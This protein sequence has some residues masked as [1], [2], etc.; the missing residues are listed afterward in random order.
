MTA[1]VAVSRR[2]QKELID[3]DLLSALRDDFSARAASYDEFAEF[4]HENFRRLGELGLLALVVPKKFGGGS[5]QLTDVARLIGAVASGDASTALV[6]AMHCLMHAIL[7][8]R[9]PSIYETVARAAV[10]GGGVLNALRAEPDLGS[11]NRG[12]ALATVARPLA[13]GGWRIN[14][15]KA[16]ATGSPIVS[17]WLLYARTDEPNS[18]VGSWLVPAR[19]SGISYPKTWN[20]LGMRATAS[21]EAHLVDVDVGAEHLLNIINAAD[22][23]APPAVL[24]SWN[25][26]LLAALYDGIALAARDWARRFLLDRKPSN[27]GAPLATVPRLQSVVGEIESLLLVNRTLIESVALDI[28]AQGADPSPRPNLVKQVVTENAI[29]V[30]DLALSISGN[31]GLDRANPLERHHRDVLCGRVHAP[32]GD[33]IFTSAGKL[34]LG[35]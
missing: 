20:H 32:Q 4:P 28:D 23:P 11:V 14:G 9:N 17:W 2:S 19:A 1:I 29:R 12:G 26:I 33:S 7:R 35:I 18:R 6:L 34:S 21:H 25:G 5:A 8:E 22:A 27:L 13:N 16:Y 24:N 31:H 3:S 30:V 15:K 10:D